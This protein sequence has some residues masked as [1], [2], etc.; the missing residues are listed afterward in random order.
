VTARTR[1]F[2]KPAKILYLLPSL[3]AGGTEQQAAQL[4]QGLNRARFLPLLVTIYSPDLVPIEIDIQDCR[5]ES[6][7]KPLGKLGN[8]VALRRLSVLIRAERPDILQSF[9]R[10]ADL[11]SRMVGLLVGHPRVVTSLRTRIDGFWSPAWRWIERVLWRASTVIVS[12]SKAAAEEARKGL[13]VPEGRLR[14]IPNGVDLVRFHPD[15]ASMDARGRIGLARWDPLIG[16]VA[17]YSPVK[18]HETLLLALRLMRESGDWP[19]HGGALLVGGTTYQQTRDRIE[20]RI[21]ELGLLDQCEARGVSTDIVD[22]YHALDWLVLPSRHEG[23]PNT[24]LEAM[25]CGRPVIVSSAANAEG[26]VEEGKTGFVFPAGNPEAL[27]NCLRRAL[28][29]PDAT[30]RAMGREARA[31]VERHFSAAAMVNRFEALYEELLE[32]R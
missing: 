28:T 7:A 23:F 5:H 13:G 24:V 4:I 1:S 12:N 8:L 3:A 19:A 2:S 9:L 31:E 32:G 14:V 11:Y 29:L 10:P 16:M 30:R 26:I 20:A 15:L 21:R 25:A 22:V 6:L 18:D 17:R 27:A